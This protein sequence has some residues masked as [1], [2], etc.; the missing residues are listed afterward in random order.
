MSAFT[1]EEK[2]QVMAGM[3]IIG[4]I[5]KALLGDKYEREPGYFNIIDENVERLEDHDLKFK[6]HDTRIR[7]L[8]KEKRK[9]FFKGLTG[10]GLIGGGGVGIAAKFSAFSEAAIMVIKKVFPF[11]D[12]YI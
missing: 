1:R 5:D 2:E 7:K 9:S 11:I 10:G 6:N 12:K 4:K 3:E 8:E